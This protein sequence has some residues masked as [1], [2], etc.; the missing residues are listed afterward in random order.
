[1]KERNHTNAR[2]KRIANDSREFR[3]ED[4]RIKEIR[5]KENL[6]FNASF[7]FTLIAS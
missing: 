4:L 7:F 6:E 3:F 5:I 2:W 1:M